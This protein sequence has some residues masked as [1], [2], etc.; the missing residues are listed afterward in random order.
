MATPGFQE[1]FESRIKNCFYVQRNSY[2]A[3][4]VKTILFPPSHGGVH[5]KYL[6]AFKKHSR[7][8]VDYYIMYTLS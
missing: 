1:L 2:L 3:T 4:R 6:F 7:K 5:F 8:I